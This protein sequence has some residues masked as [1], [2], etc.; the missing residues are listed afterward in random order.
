MAG[1]QISKTAES[2]AQFKIA[3]PLMLAYVMDVLGMVIT[4]AVVGRLGHTE[5]AAVGITADI[6]FQLAIISMGF[7]S[8]VGVLVAGALGAKRREDVTIALLQGLWLAAAVGSVL[9]VI[10]W[11]M[12]HILRFLGQREEIIA[13]SAPYAHCFAFAIVPI[14]VFAV[15]RSFAAAMMRSG[16]VL[17]VTTASIAVQYILNRGFVLGEFGFPRWEVFGSGFAMAI[18]ALLRCCLL[19]LAVLWIVRTEKLHLPHGAGATD[20]WRAGA[21]VKLGLPVAGIVALESGLFAAASIMSGWLGAIPLAAYQM[22]MGWVSL[23]FVISLGFSE[24][25][26]VRVSYWVGARLPAAARSAGHLGMAIGVGIP[27]VLVVIPLFAPQLITRIFLDPADSAYGEIAALLSNVLAIGALF[28]VFD[29]LQ[30]IASHALRG[31]K[32]AFMPLVIAGIGY[33]A[34]GLVASYVLAFKLGW[35]PQGLW[36]GIAAGLAFTATLLALRFELLSRRR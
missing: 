17:I 30:A 26:M 16:A 12:P 18:T 1:T 34:I 25:T 20:V 13:L 19:A 4:K 11:N 22:T 15:L 36:W 24:A 33:W 7:F 21:F 9:G 14:L 23:P 6:S 3:A 35:G 8:V 2:A 5:L 10:V 31:L 27:L 32:D 29:G 28:Q